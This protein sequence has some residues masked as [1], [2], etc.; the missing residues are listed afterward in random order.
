MRTFTCDPKAS[1]AFMDAEIEKQD[2]LASKIRLAILNAIDP[3]PDVCI[4]DKLRLV[5]PVAFRAALADVAAELIGWDIYGN[6]ESF[7]E[8]VRE[9]CADDEDTLMFR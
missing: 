2:A 8:D 1:L 6:L 3:R 4:E 5:D 7:V 9:C